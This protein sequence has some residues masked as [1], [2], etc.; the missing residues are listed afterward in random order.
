MRKSIQTG[1]ITAQSR[2]APRPYNKHEIVETVH[3]PS[4]PHRFNILTQVG[5]CSDSTTHTKIP[6]IE[7]S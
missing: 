4:N 1:T 3:A 2:G 6:V 7:R 5:A